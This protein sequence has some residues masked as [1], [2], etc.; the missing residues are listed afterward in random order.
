VA[1]EIKK[2]SK[3]KKILTLYIR[4]DPTKW[5]EQFWREEGKEVYWG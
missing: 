1:Q 5:G 4:R 3:N 2:E